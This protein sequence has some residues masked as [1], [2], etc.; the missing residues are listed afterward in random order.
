MIQSVQRH[1]N[2][3]IQFSVIFFNQFAKKKNI[4]NLVPIA[5]KHLMESGSI[6]FKWPISH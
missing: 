3:L 1:F 6:K 2:T 4:E 5:V